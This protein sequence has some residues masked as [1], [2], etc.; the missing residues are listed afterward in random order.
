MHAQEITVLAERLD[1]LI[2]ALSRPAVPAD[3][4]LWDAAAVG[5]YLGVSARQVSERYALKPGFPDTIRLPSTSGRGLLRWK[6]C[7]VIAWAERQR[8]KS[9]PRARKSQQQSDS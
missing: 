4:V 3:K 7:E 1:R 6:A 5:A 8:P 2:D 9:A